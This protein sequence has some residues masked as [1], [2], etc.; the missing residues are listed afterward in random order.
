[1]YVRVEVR[2]GAKRE[3]VEKKGPDALLVSVREPAERNLANRRVTALVAE[4]F[5][6]APGAVRLISGH[7]S[8]RKVFSVKEGRV[9]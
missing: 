7:R 6:V 5:G 8:P 4:H 1:M 9:S 2:P 3:S